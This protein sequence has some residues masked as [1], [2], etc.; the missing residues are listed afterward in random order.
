MVLQDCDPTAGRM[1]SGSEWCQEDKELKG[2]YV[3]M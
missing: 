1:L 3:C 2:I